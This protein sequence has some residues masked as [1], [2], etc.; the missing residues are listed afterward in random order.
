M[1]DYN[2]AE[3]A[4]TLFEES[5]DAL[6]LFDPESEQLLEINPLAQRLSGFTRQQILRFNVDYLFR[7]ESPGGLVRLRQAFRKT[8]PFHAQDG[9]LLRHQQDGVWIPVSLTVSRLH[10]E[11]RTLGLIMARDITEQRSTQHQLRQK[12]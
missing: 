4:Q 5:G 8:G 10:A 3:L 1:N 12:E 9:F 7:A 11:P 2:L 6:F